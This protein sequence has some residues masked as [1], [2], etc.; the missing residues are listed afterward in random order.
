MVLVVAGCEEP[1]LRQLCRFGPERTVAR[2]GGSFIR[3]VSLARQGRRYLAV[4]TDAAG[5]QARALDEEG[6]PLGP[7][8]Q[9]GRP[10]VAVDVE[11]APGG[12]VVGVLRRGSLIW[13]GGDA[14]VIEVDF[15]GRRTGEETLVGRAGYY[16]RG[17]D[18]VVGATGTPVMVWQDGTPGDLAVRL[19]GAGEEV[20]RLSPR[21][22]NA[23][24][25]TLLDRGDHLIAA[26][27]QYE[28]QQPVARVVGR[29]LSPTGEPEG[30]PTQLVETVVQAPWPALTAVEGGFGMV[31]RDRRRFDTRDQLVFRRFSDELHQEGS[32]HRV[33][34][35]NGRTRATLLTN[36][37]VW[38][39]FTL[40][41]WSDEWIVALDRFSGEGER[42]GAQLHVFADEVVFTDV[43]VLRHRDRYVLLMAEERPRTR[44]QIAPI[45]CQV[46]PRRR[47]VVVKDWF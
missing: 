13:G 34:R 9:I 25:P 6:R 27:G 26:W 21:S 45:N 30:E 12:Y 35:Y 37:E 42:I 22:V 39:A 1:R 28:V 23:C 43:D 47:S 18:V 38:A 33:G 29:R 24:C 8:H 19:A 5:T 32:S 14:A 3:G 10:A 2:G 41:S 20:I 4:W 46:G 31:Y 36:G 7:P 17:L 40:R 16:S 44:V 15:D 11:A